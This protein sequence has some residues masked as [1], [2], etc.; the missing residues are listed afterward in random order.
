MAIP[1]IQPD[2]SPSLLQE[3]PLNVLLTRFKPW[4]VHTENT[5]TYEQSKVA[6][7]WYVT[8]EIQ[9]GE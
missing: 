1:G 4:L 5:A 9:G 8:N 2:T 7:F 6:D 3:G